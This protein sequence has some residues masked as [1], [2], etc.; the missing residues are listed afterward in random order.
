[1]IVLRA[2][3]DRTDRLMVDAQDSLMNLSFLI[4]G[5]S[6]NA[7]PSPRRVTCFCIRSHNLLLARVAFH[8]LPNVK[9]AEA[10]EGRRNEGAYRGGEGTSLGEELT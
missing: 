7:F 6:L 5:R 2:R 10:A 3:N 8:A 1:M 9:A 4:A